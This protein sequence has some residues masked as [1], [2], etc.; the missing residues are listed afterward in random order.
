MATFVAVLGTVVLVVVGAA[1]L[2]GLVLAALLVTL[3]LIRYSLAL[4]ATS[5]QALERR[6]AASIDAGGLEQSADSV[7]EPV[8]LCPDRE[9]E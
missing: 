6:V 1:A 2:A 9:S 7:T 5:P 8:I 3:R 4:L